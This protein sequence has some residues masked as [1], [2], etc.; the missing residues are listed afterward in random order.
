[1]FAD[2]SSQSSEQTPTNSNEAS[3]T[4]TAEYTPQANHLANSPVT[5]IFPTNGPFPDAD[6]GTEAEFTRMCEQLKRPIQ[7]LLKKEIV[8]R[9]RNPL[10]FW[11]SLA[12]TLR[13]EDLTRVAVSSFVDTMGH[14][15]LYIASNDPMTSAQQ[16]EV[17]EIV[18]MFLDLR[19]ANEIAAKLLPRHLPYIIK[20]FDKITRLQLEAFAAEYPGDLSSTVKTLSVKNISGDALS[21]DDIRP[22]LNLI[23]ENRKS[24]RAMKD[25]STMGTSKAAKKRP[26]ICARW[27]RVG[28]EIH[29]VLKK[30]RK[31]QPDPALQSLSRHF[32][33]T[34]LGCHAELAILKTA[35]DCCASRTLYIGVS[36]RPC[37]CCSLF[38]K[39]VQ[40]NQSTTFDIS[41]VTT[42]GKL[43]GRWNRIEGC[44]DKEFNQVWAKVIEDI[45][46]RKKY[47]THQTDDNSSESDDDYRP[48]AEL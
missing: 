45:T 4:D 9:K 20:Q 7:M 5:K 40:E 46:A 32:Q 37:Y 19:P 6:P 47:L 25:D 24:L 1:M 3:M 28:E 15:K 29:F 43:Y 39:A 44:F 14:N 8:W 30:V 48:T 21:L 35:K 38:F 11:Q 18:R 17:T 36:K 23:V 27:I 34:S 10:H 13:S 12:F 31:H 33:F 16:Q 42:H 26:I 41:I 22:L 2:D